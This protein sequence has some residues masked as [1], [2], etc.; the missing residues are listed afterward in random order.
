MFWDYIMGL[1]ASTFLRSLRK[2]MQN[3]KQNLVEKGLFLI[4]SGK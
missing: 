2:T 4:V 3:Y 1:E